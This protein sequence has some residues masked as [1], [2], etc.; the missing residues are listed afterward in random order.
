VPAP[1]GV[2]AGAVIAL[3]PSGVFAAS[4]Q[5]VVVLQF[6]IKPE[7]TNPATIV[8]PDTSV[9]REVSDAA[10]NVLPTSYL[11]G[12]VAVNPLPVLH[13]GQQGARA[14]ISWPA[15]SGGFFLQSADTLPAVSWGP[16]AHD[17]VTN[18]SMST[19]TVAPTN[20]QT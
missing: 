7:A 3:S 6:A 1:T 19:V 2:R 4:T 17:I 11:D 5:Q 10:A 8:F 20:A 18:G 13:I 9:M 14:V 15:S 12:Q 16:V